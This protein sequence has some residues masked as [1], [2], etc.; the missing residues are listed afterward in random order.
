RARMAVK[1]ALNVDSSH[2]PSRMLALQLAQAEQDWEGALEQLGELEKLK[3]DADYLDRQRA[4]A[5]VNLGRTA[6]A[7]KIYQGWTE[8]HPKQFAGYQGLA[9]LLEQAK[10]YKGALAELR[11]WQAKVGKKPL[12]N[13]SAFQMEVRLLVRTGKEGEANRLIESYIEKQ[14]K[15][16]RKELEDVIAKA[17]GK[18]K[19]ELEKARP[20]MESNNEMNLQVVAANAL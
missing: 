7:K 14:Q 19:E 11:K 6:E 17:K 3:V 8:K 16:Y 20:Q 10:D 4:I 13:D 12:R 2:L 5:Y 9:G 18:T 15:D 1:A